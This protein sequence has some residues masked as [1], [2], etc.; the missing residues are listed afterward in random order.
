MGKRRKSTVNDVQKSNKV[1]I[2]ARNHNQKL[3]LQSL[4][5]NSQTIVLGPAGTGK[6][7]I[8]SVTAARL[9]LRGDINKIIITRPRVEVDEEWGALPGSLHKKTAPWAQPIT[10]VLEECMGKARFIEAERSGDVEVLPLAFMRGRTLQDAFC[11]LDEAQNTTVN[12]MKMFVTR[13]GENSK[14]VINGDIAQT[15]IRST[16]GLGWALDMM[17]RYS[18]LPAR[19][20]EFE[21]KDVER[22]A[23]CAAWVRAMYEDQSQEID[24]AG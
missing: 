3:Y 8:A 24:Q 4:R 22:S 2:I 5:E 13:I 10:E 1:E 17:R 9:Y 20:I 11:I 19:V 15:D 12:Q 23:A 6:T 18:Y 14:V 21:W 7:F 16:S